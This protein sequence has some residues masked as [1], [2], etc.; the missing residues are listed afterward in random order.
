MDHAIPFVELGQWFSLEDLTPLVEFA[1]TRFGCEGRTRC[2]RGRL[3]SWAAKISECTDAG[4]SRQHLFALERTVVGQ[5]Q[6]EV[7]VI[8]LI[9]ESTGQGVYG[10]PPS[11]NGCVQR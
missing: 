5:L 8:D 3:F 10:L 4:A 2:A 7:L 11:E 9:D 1:H 6:V